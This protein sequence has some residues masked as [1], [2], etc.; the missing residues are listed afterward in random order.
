MPSGPGRK[1]KCIKGLYVRPP[2]ILLLRQRRNGLFLGLPFQLFYLLPSSVS[3]SLPL[4]LSFYVEIPL[5]AKLNASLGRIW[6]RQHKFVMSAFMTPWI[7]ALLWKILPH[8]GQGRLDIDID[9]YI[10]PHPHDVDF[11]IFLFLDSY[12][13]SIWNSI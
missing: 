1:Q 12:F 9:I 10:Y 11:D 4:F 3:P 6:V 2:N 8:P 13:K 7:S 5:L